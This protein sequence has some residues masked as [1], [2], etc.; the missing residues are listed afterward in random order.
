MQV[1]HQR[2]IPL[3]QFLLAVYKVGSL[4]MNSSSL[5]F[6][7]PTDVHENLKDALILGKIEWNAVP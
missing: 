2:S 5:P 1:M 7:G 6:S 4:F 3:Q